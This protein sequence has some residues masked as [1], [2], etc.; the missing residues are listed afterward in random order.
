MSLLSDIITL[1]SGGGG[2]PKI[3]GDP[4][5]PPRGWQ[6]YSRQN[7]SGNEKTDDQGS[8]VTEGKEKLKFS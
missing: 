5:P 1:C 7:A 6:P 8:L 3:L 2:K 4:L